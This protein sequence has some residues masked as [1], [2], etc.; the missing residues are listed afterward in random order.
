MMVRLAIPRARRPAMAAVAVYIYSASSRR[1]HRQTVTRSRQTKR[2]IRKKTSKA[3]VKTKTTVIDKNKTRKVATSRMA[4]IHS[5]RKVN[6]FLPFVLLRKPM[7]VGQHK[8]RKK[9]LFQAFTAR[10]PWRRTTC[11]IVLPF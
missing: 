2:A 9:S 6:G 11:L 1:W 8:P 7:L 5:T 3:V 10:L 4:R